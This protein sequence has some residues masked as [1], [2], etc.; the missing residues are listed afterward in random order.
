MGDMPSENAIDQDV[1]VILK[2]FTEY[3]L[4]QMN[5]ALTLMT[6]YFCDD[7]VKR[8]L[9]QDGKLNRIQF[10][11]AVQ[12]LPSGKS[13]TRFSISGKDRNQDFGPNATVDT[14]TPE[15]EEE[16]KV[17]PQPA[18]VQAELEV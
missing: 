6:Y 2:E 14:T 11:A 8:D 4:T 7:E 5:N 13:M 18:K 12:N 15:P 3:D 1:D 9:L 16:A 10:R 17:A